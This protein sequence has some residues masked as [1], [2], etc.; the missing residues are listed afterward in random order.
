MSNL[1]KFNLNDDYFL[2]ARESFLVVR[3]T[4]RVQKYIDWVDNNR[5]INPGSPNTKRNLSIVEEE[6][7]I[8]RAHV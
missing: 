1:L 5:C 6:K 2:S 7:E 8:G 3:D 4:L